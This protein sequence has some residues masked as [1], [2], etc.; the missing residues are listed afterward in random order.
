MDDSKSEKTRL[1]V[2]IGGTGG[3]GSEI[4]R[5]FVLNKDRVCVT[6]LEAS[7]AAVLEN[8]HGYPMD[9]LSE[10]SVSDVFGSINKEHG[11]IDVIVFAASAP[12]N[13]KPFHAKEWDD[14]N[15]HIGIQVKGL[16]STVKSVAGQIKE[17]HKIKFIILLTE[18]CI[19]AP[20]AQLSDY[21]AAKYGLMGL[22]KSLS[23][24]L[25]KYGCTVNM[26]SPGMTDTALLSN[27]PPKLIEMA[28]MKNPLKRIAQPKDVASV[29]LFLASR[30]SDYLNGVNIAVNGGN[31]MF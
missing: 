23:V 5:S 11:N 17:N 14:F 28:A 6:G 15:R 24:E 9:L 25:A 8:C 4:A 29:A 13:P 10:A 19:G 16:F 12:I 2:V 31:V 22:A 3:I 27:F 1:V 7:G 20:P 21:I 26:I 18:G 30:D